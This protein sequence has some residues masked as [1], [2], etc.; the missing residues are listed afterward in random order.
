MY[1]NYFFD[2]KVKSEEHSV[3]KVVIFPLYLDSPLIAGQPFHRY[4]QINTD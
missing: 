1:L 3:D 4:I 2:I